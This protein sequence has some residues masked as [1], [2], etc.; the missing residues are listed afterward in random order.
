MAVQG[1]L[2][3]LLF[4]IRT[5]LD[6]RT[7]SPSL[8]Q[9]CS[10]RG[11][12]GQAFSAYVLMLST[13]VWRRHPTTGAPAD[14]LLVGQ[15]SDLGELHSVGRRSFL[16]LVLG[17]HDGDGQGVVFDSRQGVRDINGSCNRCQWMR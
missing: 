7:C 8:F 6:L 16:A 4:L 1:Y 17:G 12:P 10:L 14:L 3:D 15:E 5:L 13:F 11:A 9:V 2:R